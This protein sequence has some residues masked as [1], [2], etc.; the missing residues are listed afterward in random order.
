MRLATLAQNVLDKI[1][2]STVAYYV[3]NSIPTVTMRDY[4]N[5]RLFVPISNMLH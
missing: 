3:L 2:D 1:L 4:P 5:M